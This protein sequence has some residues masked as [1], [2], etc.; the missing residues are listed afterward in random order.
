M[1]AE[2]TML[3]TL[4]THLDEAVVE[5]GG[6]GGDNDLPVDGDAMDRES[7]EGGTRTPTWPSHVKSLLRDSSSSS[8][9]E[10]QQ[11]QQLR[12]KRSLVKSK[13]CCSFFCNSCSTTEVTSATIPTVPRPI[14]TRSFERTLSRKKLF[15]SF[16]HPD[17]S[18]VFTEEDETSTSPSIGIN[19]RH[20]RRRREPDL[21][22]AIESRGKEFLGDGKKTKKVSVLEVQ[23]RKG[24]FPSG[25][26]GAGD[27]AV[28]T[29]NGDSYTIIAVHPEIA[30]KVRHEAGTSEE[31]ENVRRGSLLSMGKRL[32]QLK[33]YKSES[34]TAEGEVVEIESAKKDEEAEEVLNA[35]K[36][37]FEESGILG[38]VTAMGNTLF[39]KSSKVHIIDGHQF[40]Q[41]S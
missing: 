13:T 7:G 25:G 18:F 24:S 27:D 16:S 33:V 28:K 11:Q 40:E 6:T 12:K 29:G 41:V 26:A 21:E 23:R 10:T 38:P 19:R 3:R 20:W 32:A 39:R 4:R 37:F 15:P 5:G 8:V 30:V 1:A 34:D 22:L 17:T 14:P 31:V 9:G 2:S 35:A 36:K